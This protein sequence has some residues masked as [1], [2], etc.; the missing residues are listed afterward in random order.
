MKQSGGQ[1]QFVD[2]SITVRFETLEA[3]SGYEFKSEIIRGAVPRN[4][5]PGVMKRLEEVSSLEKWEE[6]IFGSSHK[7]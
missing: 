3:G 4:Y 6:P 7:R 2:I 1:G 5:N